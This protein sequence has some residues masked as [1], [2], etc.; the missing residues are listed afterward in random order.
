MK[1]FKQT[2]AKAVAASAAL[3]F[4]LLVAVIANAFGN[5]IDSLL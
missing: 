4:L 3:A 2:L 1:T 5:L